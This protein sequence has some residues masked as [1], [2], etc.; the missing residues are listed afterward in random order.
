MP[1]SG[2]HQQNQPLYTQ[3]RKDNPLTTQAWNTYNYNGTDTFSRT[4]Q[5]SLEQGVAS[6]KT[7]ACQW[8]IFPNQFNM[9]PLEKQKNGTD[10]DNPVSQT[11]TGHFGKSTTRQQPALQLEISSEAPNEY[12]AAL[13][14][15]LN[16]VPVTTPVQY[17]LQ[18][19]NFQDKNPKWGSP[20][21]QI[22]PDSKPQGTCKES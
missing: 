11:D 21:T 22:L 3:Q 19:A 10:Y 4:I 12:I 13:Q 20:S 16:Q 17:Q 7:T 18:A 8:G 5:Q 1:T 2:P 9:L 14:R 15:A 6:G